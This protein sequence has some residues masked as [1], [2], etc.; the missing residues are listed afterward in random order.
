[1]RKNDEC[2]Y[3]EK[4]SRNSVWLQQQVQLLRAQV[5][6][7]NIAEDRSEDR[8][9][10][11][12]TLATFDGSEDA[13]MWTRKVETSF[14]ARKINNS[15]QSHILFECSFLRGKAPTWFDAKQRK[16]EKEYRDAFGSWAEFVAEI[17]RESEYDKR[18]LLDQFN[19]L[20]QTGPVP[21][22]AQSHRA[23]VNQ[24]QLDIPERWSLDKFTHGLRP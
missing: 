23:L 2:F 16:A 1:V 17:R 6:A 8:G 19:N 21:G 15:S 22:Y 5:E 13:A 10:E 9:W 18:F 14:K 20:R 3:K 24:N 4:K 7:A 12:M 11:K